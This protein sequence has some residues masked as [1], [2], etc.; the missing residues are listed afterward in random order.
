MSQLSRRNF[1]QGM[2][3]MGTGIAV[4]RSG[5]EGKGQAKPEA[6]NPNAWRGLPDRVW[7]GPE[8]WANPLQDWRISRGKLECTNAAGNRNVHWLTR[9]L[10]EKGGTFE[11]EVTVGRAEEGTLMTGKGSAGFR[12]GIRGPVEDYRSAVI[13]GNGLDAGF[14]AQGGLFLGRAKSQSPVKE[15]LNRQWIRL[16]LSAEQTGEDYLLRLFAY[17]AETGELLDDVRQEHTPADQLHGTIALVNNYSAGGR[18]ATVPAFGFGRFVFHDWQVTGSKVEEHPERAFGPILFS[19]YTLSGGILK[20]TAQMP[21]LGEEDSQSVKLEIQGGQA[22]AWK[23]IGEETIHPEARTATFRIADW[24]DKTDMPYRL[25]YVQNTKSG[26]EPRARVY[27]WTGII[28]KDPVDKDV[29]T[30]ADV[31]CNI[32]TAFPNAPFVANMAKLDP[33][34]LAFTGDQFYES[35]GG[36][37]I[38]TAP[39]D[40]AILDYLRKWWLHGWTWRELM[41]DRPSISIPDDHDVYQGNIWGE[42]G[43]GQQETQE[44]GGYRLPPEWV[45]VVHRTQTSHHPDPFDPTPA[46]QNISVYYGHLTYGRLSFAILADRMFKTGPDGEVPP[47]GGR[48]DHVTDPNFDPK[49]ADLE[50]LELLG[51]RQLKFLREWA[52]DWKGADMKIVVSQT[53]FTAMATTH[54]G[55]RQRLRADYDTNG[56]PQTERDK[57]LKEMR[58][59]FAVHLAGDQHLPAVVHYGIDDFKDAGVAFA[60]PAVNTG[61]PRWWEPEEPGQNR[62]PGSPENTGDFLDHFGNKMTVLAVK[63][64]AAEPSPKLLEGLQDKASGMGVVRFD[65]R[66]QEITI[67]CWPFLA[68][69]TE[70]HSQFPGWPIVVKMLDNYARKPAGYL[71]T[72]KIQGT[73]NPVVQVINDK[74]QEIEYTL[75]IRG[76][77]FRPMI[78]DAEATYTVKIGSEGPIAVDRLKNLKPG[79]EGTIEV[80]V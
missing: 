21:P 55:N 25:S 52:A 16:K 61:Y 44:A 35:S 67:E 5:E 43:A 65:K 73:E 58:K 74:T 36:Y 39:L 64:G 42:G 54:G 56:W 13:S 23:M 9:P 31:S 27:E 53:I 28:R 4:A 62:L 29:I 24:N 20:L 3:A 78:F 34:L 50:G 60:G 69:P 49:T 30:V 32:H 2:S 72:L 1:L 15:V 76:K 26:N 63:N 47:T 22:P 17:S 12:I 6:P 19:Q 10:S 68:D 41:K 57:A 46:R 77:S 70:P 11:M 37:G 71:P 7:I 33:D 66:K 80:A 8:Y 79:A 38:Q 51:E 18:R 14:T 40:K 45:N 59:C 48:A 75:R